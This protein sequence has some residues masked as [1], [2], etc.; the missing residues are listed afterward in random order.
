LSGLFLQNYA[1]LTGITKTFFAFTKFLQFLLFNKVIFL[2]QRSV[3]QFVVAG[4][5][6]FERI[7]GSEKE[8]RQFEMHPI[9]EP[10]YL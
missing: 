2:N 8:M 4:R 7:K 1:F 6:P 3:F 9:K 10:D 5:F